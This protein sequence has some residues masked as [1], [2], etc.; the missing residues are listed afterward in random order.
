MVNIYDY[1]DWIE[2]A[3]K[4]SGGTHVFED[5]VDLVAR[6]KA[7]LWP[8]PRGVAI[9]E[10]IEYPR[11]RVLHVFLAAGELDQVLDGIDSVAEWGRTQGCTS[12]TM[13]GRLGWQRVLA[14]HGFI[15]VLVT[16]EREVDGGRIGRTADDEH[17]GSRVA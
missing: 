4:H 13:S 14:K 8:A 1:R 12:L 10:I 9:T 11:K 7:Q 17:A 6:G 5:V 16:M 2:S 15:P 3:L